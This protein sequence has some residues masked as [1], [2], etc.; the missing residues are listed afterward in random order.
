MEP[1]ICVANQMQC[2]T[3][4]PRFCYFHCSVCANLHYRQQPP[5]YHSGVLWQFSTLG[6]G[7]KSPPNQYI[8]H[9]FVHNIC[10]TLGR[11]VK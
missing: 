6:P 5:C 3:T 4:G 2:Q 9:Y 11:E 1:K 8:Y 7:M 10:P